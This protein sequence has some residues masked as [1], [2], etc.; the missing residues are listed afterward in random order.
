[1]EEQ[2]KHEEKLAR[3]Q[4][5]QEHQKMGMEDLSKMMGRLQM[6]LDSVVAG[7]T[8]YQ[9]AQSQK[10]EAA[11]QKMERDGIAEDGPEGG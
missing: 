1:M 11:S 10:M 6:T 5:R 7:T 3:L 9:Q 2:L 4:E 8:P